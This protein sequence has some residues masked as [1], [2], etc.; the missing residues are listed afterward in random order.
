MIWNKRID[1]RKNDMA[2]G[3]TFY[4]WEREVKDGRGEAAYNSKKLHLDGIVSLTLA[5]NQHKYGDELIAQ[6]FTK[7]NG[8]VKERR[9]DGY[10]RI[11]V[12][13]GIA[14]ENTATMLEEIA[15]QIRVKNER[16]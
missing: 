2:H 7:N 15:K 8:V 9:A 14:D 6:I 16:L 1:T 3:I 10:N 4:M 11:Q 5:L 12:Y 13:L